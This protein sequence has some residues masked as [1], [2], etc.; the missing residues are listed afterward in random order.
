MYD[1]EAHL[2]KRE[3]EKGGRE[4][5]SRSYSALV[6]V[7]W[8][9]RI[10]YNLIVNQ[11]VSSQHVT[12]K[13]RQTGKKKKKKPLF[14]SAVTN[15]FRSGFVCDILLLKNFFFIIKILGTLWGKY[16]VLGRGGNGTILEKGIDPRFFAFS[17]TPSSG[18]HEIKTETSFQEFL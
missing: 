17:S 3:G 9:L 15:P 11:W 7:S 18:I 2:G 16:Q 4:A 8:I 6:P 1:S 14:F 10:F 12:I 5:I 13:N